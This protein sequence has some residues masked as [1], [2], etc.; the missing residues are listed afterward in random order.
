MHGGHGLGQP[1]H[2]REEAREGKV[3]GRVGEDVGG[4]AD[5]DGALRRGVEVDV[6]GADRV[7]GDHAEVG[8]RVHEL[9]VDAVAEERE[10]ARLV[11]GVVTQVVRGRRELL[12]PEVDVVLGPQPLE[13]SAG[14]VAGDEDAGHRSS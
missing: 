14:Q 11:G 2:G 5:G 6:V 13:R 7:V 3:G 1:P 10:Q 8:A 9:R 12:A 4:D